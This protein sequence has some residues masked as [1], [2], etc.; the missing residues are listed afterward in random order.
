MPLNPIFGVAPAGANTNPSQAEAEA[1]TATTERVWT[2]ERVKQAIAALTVLP[3]PDFTST[4]QTVTVDTLLSVAHS[5][6]AIPTLV[7]VVL[8]CTTA[9]LG[10]EQ[11]DEVFFSGFGALVGTAD[12]G[13]TMA[14]DATN[15]TITQGLQ[16]N[17][18]NEDDFNGANIVTTNWRWVVRAWA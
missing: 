12:H 11:N 15:V 7:H 3:A 6:G 16:I 2:A 10:Y 1:G 13:I 14:V 8:R 5:L 17:C 9:D 18:L 4:E